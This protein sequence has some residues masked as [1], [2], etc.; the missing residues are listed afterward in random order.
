MAETLM[1][2]GKIFFLDHKMYCII[3]LKFQNSEN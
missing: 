1:N 3:L 2:D